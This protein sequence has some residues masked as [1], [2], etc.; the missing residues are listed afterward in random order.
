ME[1][2]NEIVRTLF[3][4][5]C[6]PLGVIVSFP[7]KGAQRDPATRGGITRGVTGQAEPLYLSVVLGAGGDAAA[8]PAHIHQKEEPHGGPDNTS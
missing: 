5:N 7:G 1:K 8:V 2:K 3:L 6:R 4:H